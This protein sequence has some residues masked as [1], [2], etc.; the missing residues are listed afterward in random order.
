MYVAS[1]TYVLCVCECDMVVEECDICRRVRIHVILEGVTWQNSTRTGRYG[2]GGC[3]MYVGGS[4]YIL[5]YDMHRK[6]HMI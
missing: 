6:V 1:I 4:V 5:V 2:I 3:D